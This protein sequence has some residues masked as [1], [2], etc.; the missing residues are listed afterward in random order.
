MIEK[1]AP[2]RRGEILEPLTIKNKVVRKTIRKRKKT[3][4]YN[5][6]LPAND[7]L[8][9]YKVVSYW[10][11][12]QYEI[13]QQ[14]L[15]IMYYLYSAH[16]FSYTEFAEWANNFAW[17]KNRIAR[18]REKDWIHVWRENGW[19]EKRIYEMTR[20]GKR[21]M[22]SIYKK[23]N[24]QEPIPTSTR[25]NPVMNPNGC[26]MDKVMANSIR[27]MNDATKELRQHPSQE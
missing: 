11:R 26:Y 19:K 2:R 1:K 7:Y 5:R 4:T 3:L 14:D 17:D 12:K 16:L 27:R 18:L 15:E 25:R 20:K 23:L 21:M 24:G 8:K 22:S 9:Y 6:V 13:S 10:A